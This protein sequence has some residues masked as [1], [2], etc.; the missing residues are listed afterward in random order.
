MIRTG[1][2]N[3]SKDRIRLNRIF[4]ARYRERTHDMKYDKGEEEREIR[5]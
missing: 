5:H 4:N 1:I 3:I 2:T